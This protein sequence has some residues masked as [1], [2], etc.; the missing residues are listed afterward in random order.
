[1]TPSLEYR[2]RQHRRR[3][4]VRSREYRQRR[5]AHGVW[6]RLRRVLAN[7]RTAHVISGEDARR[8]MA[9]GRRPEAVGRELDPPKL[10]IFAPAERVARIASAQPVEV[11]L[12]AEV[13]AA[14]CLALTPFDEERGE[15]H[16]T[17]ESTSSRSSSPTERSGR[18]PPPS[19][20]CSE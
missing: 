8:L 9:E 18:R 3:M 17:S 6:F 15:N 11:R 13:L 7:A 10:I 2:L 16:L 19:S 14:E 5:H 12:T 4:I 1:M 20:S